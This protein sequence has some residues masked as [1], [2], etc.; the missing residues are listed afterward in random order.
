M[1]NLE[2]QKQAADESALARAAVTLAAELL[3]QSEK[4][5]TWSEKWQGSQLARLMQDPAGKA[6][7]LAMADQVF[8][9]P[10]PRRSAAQFRH[11]VDLFGIPQY[12]SLPER[13]AM[14][15][16]SIT[17]A[18][19][20]SLVMPA[21]TGAMRSQ[22]SKVI[23]PAENSKLKPLLNHRRSSG[24][25]MNLNQL[26]E[27]VLG[28]KEAEKRLQDIV[29]RIQN[30]DCDYLSVKLS[31][32]FSQ[33]HL[34][35]YQKTLDHVCERLRLLYRAAI[36]HPQKDGQPKFINLDMEEYRDLRLTCDAFQ[37]VLDEPEFHQLRAGIVLQ[38]YL[39]D[40]WPFQQKLCAWARE[41]VAKGGARIKIRIVKGANLAMEKV[42][43]ELHDWPCA[44]YSTKEEVDAN[45][46]RMVH[47][48]CRTENAVAVSHGIASH[49]LFDIAYALLLREREGVT[50]AIE[51]EMLEGMANHQAR[52]VKE[53]ASDLLLYAPIVQ[54]HDFHTAIA[55]LV[56]RLD[57]NTAPENFLHDLFGLK[58]GDSAWERQKSRFLAAVARK[59]EVDT[60][61]RRHQNRLTDSSPPLPSS[62]PFH[63]A[64]DT[65]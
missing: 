56:R 46:K 3:S 33:I 19:A 45:Y 20:P 23:L 24:M 30:P 15:L 22:A 5:Q 40:S 52:T 62:A 37:R 63:N 38:A 14:R 57:E 12:L 48:A 1:E 60:G 21:I 43:A 6:F 29:A 8:R 36:S 64:A 35:A 41:R 2:K 58:P 50:D 54:R 55:Y 47:E 61:P 7:T 10:S 39:P 65:D 28:E 59:D 31:S 32:I 44:V 26:G 34:V 25:R 4:S 9:P 11:L 49:N 13:I 42:E 27:A 17:S 16:G 18:F 51:F 53:A